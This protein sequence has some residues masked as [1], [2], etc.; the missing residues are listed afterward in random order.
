[1]NGSGSPNRV[2]EEPACRTLRYRCVPISASARLALPIAVLLTLASILTTSTAAQAPVQPNFYAV[3]I[4][5]S[6]FE[7]LSKDDWLQ[8]ADKDAQAFYDFITSPRG[9]AFPP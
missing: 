3:V 8:Y 4:G 6:Q 9:R 5:I 1:M 7:N 2:C